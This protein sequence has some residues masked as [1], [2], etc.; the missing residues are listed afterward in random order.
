MPFGGTDPHIDSLC[1]AISLYL[2]CGGRLEARDKNQERKKNFHWTKC[3]FQ[4]VR[5]RAPSIQL[6]S[7]HPIG[8]DLAFELTVCKNASPPS[9]GP[10]SCPCL[11]ASRASEFA[12]L[13]DASVPAPQPLA[14][15]EDPLAD[16]TLR[17][18]QKDLT[19]KADNELFQKNLGFAYRSQR[20]TQICRRFHPYYSQAR[21]S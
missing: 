18:T 20:A 15:I 1:F 3:Q 9:S 10:R 11:A 4:R 2:V 8:T 6:N 14:D 5:T 16:P 7:L 19:P 21:D 17:R 12:R 13:A